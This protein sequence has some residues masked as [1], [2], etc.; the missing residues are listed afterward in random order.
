MLPVEFSHDLPVTD[1]QGIHHFTL[2]EQLVPIDNIK[3]QRVPFAFIPVLGPSTAQIPCVVMQRKTIDR[4]QLPRV[5]ANN[6]F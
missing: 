5:F 1:Y 3:L 6:F 2:S 4:A